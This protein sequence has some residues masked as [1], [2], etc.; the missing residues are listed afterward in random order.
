MEKKYSKDEFYTRK[1]REENYPARSVY[2][3]KEINEKYKIIK[4][5]DKIL[6]LGC[7]PGSWLLYIS[8]KIG[9]RGM[10]VGVD[11]KDINIPEK[12]NIFFTKEDI[13][14][15]ETQKLKTEYNVVV[16]D[17]APNTSGIDFADV[18]ESLELSGEALEIAKK[19]LINSGNFVCKILEGEGIDDFF[20]KI[21]SSFEFC[22]RFRPKATRRES[23]EIYIVAKNFKNE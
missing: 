20:K 21:K 14:E 2:K 19:V 15:L 13:L 22:K 1:A 11:L 16:S 5:G 10:V 4:S 9:E 8:E 23:R 7:A 12:K 18:E 17:L 6:D 3:L